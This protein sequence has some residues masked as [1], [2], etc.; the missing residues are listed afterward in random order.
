MQDHLDCMV[1]P[2]FNYA[3]RLNTI[4]YRCWAAMHKGRAQR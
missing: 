3:Q 4:G 2:L 1:L